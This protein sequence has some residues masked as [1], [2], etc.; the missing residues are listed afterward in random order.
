VF[1]VSHVHWWFSTISRFEV[2]SGD[3]EE[4]CFTSATVNTEDH[5]QRISISVGKGIVIHSWSTIMIIL[6]YILKIFVLAPECRDIVL[7]A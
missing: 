6:L 7:E 3:I 4:N 2:L 1:Y 5:K